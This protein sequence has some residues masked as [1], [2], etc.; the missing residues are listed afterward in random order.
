MKKLLYISVLLFGLGIVSCQKED[1]RPIVDETAVVP[2]WGSNEKAINNPTGDDG[3]AHGN[4]SGSTS[5]G[6]LVDD[7]GV[8]N[9]GITDPNTD[10][11]GS[12][13]GKGSK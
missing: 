12:K 13:K 5:G 7:P 8:D 9:G 4:N 6:G 3:D 11:D 2:T 10:P 1:I